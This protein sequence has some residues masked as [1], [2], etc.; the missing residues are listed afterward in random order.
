[1]LVD[2]ILELP[3]EVKAQI[4][5]I[6]RKAG[7]SAD[8]FMVNALSETIRCRTLAIARRIRHQSESGYTIDEI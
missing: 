1:M 2:T 6:A 5:E 3:L 7:I 8:A 4:D